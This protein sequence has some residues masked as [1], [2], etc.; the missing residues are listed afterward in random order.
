VTKLIPASG[1]RLRT[2]GASPTRRTEGASPTLRTEGASPTLRTEGASPTLRTEGAS[3]TLRTEGA[4][5]TRR[6]T[7]ADKRQ[8]R[9][10]DDRNHD[11]RERGEAPQDRIIREAECRKITTTSRAHRWRLE[12]ENK[13]PRRVVLGARSVGWWLSEVLAWMD[14][15]PRAA[16]AGSPQE[17]LPQAAITAATAARARRKVALVST[18]ANC[19]TIPRHPRTKQRRGTVAPHQSREDDTDFPRLPPAA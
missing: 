15:L 10:D 12:N 7:R 5:P 13:F 16:D 6:T 9:A 2:E 1:L 8:A 14:S 17:A 3:P 19:T 4:S 11:Q 18:D